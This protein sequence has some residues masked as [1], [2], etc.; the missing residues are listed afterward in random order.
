MNKITQHTVEK[1]IAKRHRDDMFFTEVKN[2]SSMGHH[3]RIDALAIKLSWSSPC[4]TGYE[5][6]VDR[7]D[8]LGDNKWMSY[9]PMCNQLYFATPPGIIQKDEI[10][11][12]CGLVQLSSNGT[13]IRTIK[14][15]PYRQI[16]PPVDMFMYL[17][18]KYIGPRSSYESSAGIRA[19]ALLQDTSVDAW[20]EYLDDKIEYRQ[21]GHKVSR[22]L[23]QRM[24][25]LERTA[26]NAEDNAEELNYLRKYIS[27]A[28][29]QLGLT[30]MYSYP[31]STLRLIVNHVLNNGGANVDMSKVKQAHEALGLVIQQFERSKQNGEDNINNS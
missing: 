4:I 2:G 31:D 6:K 10:P 20:K 27:E 16:E 25:E 18:M 26:N 24:R 12:Q 13:Q 9:L 21:I 28:A 8:F 7:S 1:A 17:M 29:L 3:S 22:K 5:I 15:A 23:S 19:S 11:E 14:K 30:P